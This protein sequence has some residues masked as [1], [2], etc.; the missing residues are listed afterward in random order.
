MA[1]IEGDFANLCGL[2]LPLSLCLQLQ[3][4]DLKLSEALWSAKASASGFSVSL[5]WP[6]TGTAPDKDKA[7]MARRKRRRRNNKVITRVSN[8]ETTVL[9]TSKAATEPVK[10]NSLIDEHSSPENVSSPSHL[11]DLAS[12]SEVQY[13]MKDGIHGVSYNHCDGE[14]GWTP[15]VGRRKRRSVP[16]Y[17]H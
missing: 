3:T 14:S 15:V 7:K 13:E 10:V 5:Y 9:A 8:Y 2:G 11:V 16:S 12:C 4:Q 17:K 6:T 1:V